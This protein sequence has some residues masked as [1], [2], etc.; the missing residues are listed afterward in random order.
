L[1]TDPDRYPL[2]ITNYLSL[3]SDLKGYIEN[4]GYYFKDSLTET[5]KNLDL[6]MMV[7][8]W[9]RF[10]WNDV[11]NDN[12]VAQQYNRE[13]GL[14]LSGK[15]LK[16]G[17]KKAP[18]NSVLKVITLDGNV[19]ILK[20][21]SL[22][23]F[24]SDDLLFYDSMKLVF[25][26]ENEK[27]KKQP[28]KFALDPFNP[29][30]LSNYR[31]T[32]Y[33]SFD[34]T[35]FLKQQAEEKLVINSTKV[36]V[37]DEVKIVAKRER[38]PRLLGMPGVD[39]VVDPKKLGSG[40]A[41]VFQMLQS[42]VPGVVVTG[43]PPNMSIKIRGKDPIYLYNGMQVEADFFST[44][45]PTEVDYVEVLGP[46][47]ALRYGA[48]SALNV[49]L[50]AGGGARETIGMNTVKYPGFYQT[51]EF[52]SPRYNVPDNRHSLDDKRITLCWMPVVETDA[53]GRGEVSFFT[54]DAASTY[55]IVMEG[56]TYDGYPGTASA[57]FVVE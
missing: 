11:L 25:Q 24:Y 42:Q 52:Y 17:G 46:G 54:A 18:A 35:P 10:T 50:K 13:K 15:V 38:D 49:V 37:F 41:N 2:T 19:I 36:K 9:R 43:Y 33:L 34:A 7:H 6:L 29:S 30:P 48:T 22:G 21:D 51:R 44:I 39:R 8:G 28:Y 1:I 14:P 45:S 12:L 16:A 20:P 47:S 53:L 3:T 23:A 40:Y 27:G 56:I 26:T 57:T 31:F 4:P 5:R 32:S 55:R